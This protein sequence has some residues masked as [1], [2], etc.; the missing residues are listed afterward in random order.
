MMI[1]GIGIISVKSHW[2]V[3]ITCDGCLPTDFTSS[4]C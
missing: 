3:R 4:R 1:T 2:G